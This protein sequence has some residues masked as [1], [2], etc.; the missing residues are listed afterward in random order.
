MFPEIE[1]RYLAIEWQSEGVARTIE[2]SSVALDVESLSEGGF[3]VESTIFN[4][5]HPWLGIRL[6]PV[7]EEI[8]PVFVTALGQE[9]P[10][11][12]V[13]DPQGGG[14][15]W[16]QNDGWDHSGKRHFSE[17]QR[18]PGTYNIRIG[19]VVLQIENRL[20]AFGRTDIQA[21]VDDFR[22]DLLWMIMNDAANATATG[23]GVGTGAELAEA[24]EELHAASQRVLASPAVT[25]REGLA[26]QP[27]A[28]LR[29]NVASFREYVRNPVAR[30]LTGRVFDESADIAENRY[31]R[32]MLAVCLKM[33]NAYVSAA[34]QQLGFLDRLA[35]QETERAR[36]NREMEM[37]PVDPEVFDQQTKEIKWKLDALAAL[38]DQP[39]DGAGRVG[40]FPIRLGKR[41]GHGFSFFYTPQDDLGVKAEDKIDYRVAVFPEELFEKILGCLHFC[42]NYTIIGSVESV[43]QKTNKGKQFRKLTFTSIHEVIPQTDSLEK[44][45]KKRRVLEGNNWLVRLSSNERRELKREADAGQRRAEQSLRKKKVISSSVDEMGRGAR[46]L[47]KI[48]ASFDHLGVSSSSS[49]PTGM[50]FVSNPDYATC[51]SAFK[52]IRELMERGGLDLSKLEEINSV[53][54]L[55]ASD[56]YEKW[57]L[58]KIFM[59]LVHD[60]RFE[61]E[62][63]WQEKLIAISLSRA[64][65]VRFEFLRDDL[66][67]KVALILQSEMLTGRRPDFVLEVIDI[68][69]MQFGHLDH[70][71]RPLGGLVM[72]AKFRSI[73]KKGEL[74]QT[75]DELVLA[76]GYDK[77]VANGRVFILQPSESTVRPA[78]SPLDWGVHCDYGSTQSHRKGWIQLGV[79]SAEMQATQHLKRLLTMVFQKAFPEPDENGNSTWTS[80]SF[81]LGCGECH[82]P[83]AIQAKITQSGAARWLLDCR[84][85]GV[86]TVRTHCYNCKTS[87]FKNGTL[88]TYHNTVADQVTNVICPDCGSYFDAGFS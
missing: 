68:A 58:L 41:Y 70:E 9:T 12:R 67:M 51:L 20:S 53:G 72:D 27:V 62:P 40:R 11:L 38:K 88:W 24:L 7:G 34:S 32:H 82:A 6:R 22:G 57:C 35:S 87:L 1:A 17:L 80:R 65:D 71:N 39:G 75:L 74:R 48:D 30:Q 8:V 16:L 69:K 3:A 19:D 52:K 56:I 78:S 18:S 83:E 49:F 28:K 60:F 47:A 37:R 14:I 59:L 21:Y 29:P 15:W 61:P 13:S 26:S 84:R 63:G 50:R 85:C 23:K 25:I 76:K 31:L 4:D 64:S 44:R 55:H 81:C 54:I 10:M 86:W 46:R 36:R 79:A 42:R 73:W 45:A 77:A 33:A 2:I 5:F 66:E 43:L